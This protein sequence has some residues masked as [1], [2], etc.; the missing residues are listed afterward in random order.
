MAGGTAVVGAMTA[1]FGFVTQAFDRHPLPLT[2][3][4]LGILAIS[5]YLWNESKKRRDS[6][7]AL[8]VQKA[9]S[10]TENTVVIT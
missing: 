8:I 4:V 2:I 1:I 10:Q 3:L 6:R 9:A 7:E 5:A